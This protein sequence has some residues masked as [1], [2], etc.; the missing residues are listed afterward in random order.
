MESKMT[1]L[2]RMRRDAGMTQEAL[3]EKSGV[4][5]GVIVRIER[6]GIGTV[7]GKNIFL[8]AKALRVEPGDLF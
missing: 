2:E 1:K 5:R 6:G 4:S 8:L 3:A 7:L